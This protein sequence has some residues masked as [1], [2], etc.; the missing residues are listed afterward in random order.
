MSHPHRNR[1][2]MI[3]TLWPGGTTTYSAWLLDEQVP[4]AIAGRL[5]H[6]AMVPYI[7]RCVPRNP[8]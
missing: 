5:R 8:R 3:V 2:T 1:R 4:A 7:I 6:G